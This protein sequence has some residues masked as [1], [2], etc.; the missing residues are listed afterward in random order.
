MA[1]VGDGVGGASAISVGRLVGVGV[2]MMVGVAV[3]VGSGVARSTNLFRRLQD[4]NPAPSVARIPVYRN[5]R[6][7]RF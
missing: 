1:T 5:S 3:F 7:V 4:D 6:L 2:E